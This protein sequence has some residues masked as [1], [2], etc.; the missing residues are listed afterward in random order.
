MIYG[1]VSTNN[2][3]HGEIVPLKASCVSTPTAVPEGAELESAVAPVTTLDIHSLG[4]E[5]LAGKIFKKKRRI[6][7]LPTLALCSRQFAV[8]DLLDLQA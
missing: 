6:A 1:S 7:A 4:S 8:H 3:R 2:Y 5:G